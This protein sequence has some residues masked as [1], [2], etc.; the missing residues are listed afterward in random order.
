MD[1]LI[2]TLNFMTIKTACVLSFLVFTV[3]SISQSEYQIYQ[4]EKKEVMA[5]FEKCCKVNLV[6]ILESQKPA[7]D[8]EVFLS[9]FQTGLKDHPW[10]KLSEIKYS[11][12]DE[13]IYPIY[14]YS[15]TS[16][17]SLKEGLISSSFTVSMSLERN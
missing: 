5:A 7:V 12:I 15:I 8:Y 17:I 13:I 1:Y 6:Y 11:K 14:A 9:Q 3:S 16:S 2:S 4:V 10:L